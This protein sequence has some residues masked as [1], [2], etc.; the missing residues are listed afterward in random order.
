GLE[1]LNDGQARASYAAAEGLA[2]GRVNDLRFGPDGALWAASEGGI[3]RVKNGHIATL[4]SR[5]GLPCDDVHW[6]LE[7]DAGD[8]W[9]SMPCGL[10]RIAGH[11]LGAWVR[12]AEAQQ[13]ALALP[14]TVFG[15]LDG[16][17][18]RAN[19]GGFSPHAAKAA[20]GRLWFFPLEGLSV[21]DPR[22]LS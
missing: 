13:P 14:V 10:V 5:N 9:L 21:L 18:S 17:R 2:P 16:A 8:F 22:R 20:D 11:E 19:A 4:S 7:D 3:N 15:R 12:R 6:S 1:F